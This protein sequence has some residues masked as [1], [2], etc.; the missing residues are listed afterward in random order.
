MAQLNSFG[1]KVVALEAIKKSDLPSRTIAPRREPLQPISGQGSMNGVVP[2]E[3]PIKHESPDWVPGDENRPPQSHPTSLSRPQ[4]GVGVKKETL[5]PPLGLYNATLPHETQPVNVQDFMGECALRDFIHEKLEGL[6][7]GVVGVDATVG[8][9]VCSAVRNF[10]Q[11]TYLRQ[12]EHRAELVN[13]WHAMPAH[14]HEMYKRRASHF[15]I[16][17]VSADRFQAELDRFTKENAGFYKFFFSR[18]ADYDRLAKLLDPGQRFPFLSFF[19]GKAWLKPQLR[20]GFPR[21]DGRMGQV[22]RTFP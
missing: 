16:T 12:E 1:D 8:K 5:S 15:T 9:R 20:P 21:D 10:R 19:S 11:H 18:R 6:T 13:Q 2:N 17:A 3:I 22:G 7:H 14:A 4:H